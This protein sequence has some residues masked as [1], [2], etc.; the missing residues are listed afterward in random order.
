[1]SSIPNSHGKD[2]GKKFPGA[3]SSG[4][5]CEL[6]S[7]P[8]GI[9]AEELFLAYDEENK[10]CTIKIEFA[11]TSV[12]FPIQYNVLNFS[13][14]EI[15]EHKT[16]VN[17]IVD[18][19]LKPFAHLLYPIIRLGFGFFVQ[20]ILEELKYFAENGK[21]HPRKTKAVEKLSNVA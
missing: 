4:R 18:S 5:V 13:L 15:A 7:D 20:Q 21:P 8:K 2:F 16:E 9:K 1:M 6:N 17:W 3:H 19:H 12:F 11:N 10:S 14:R